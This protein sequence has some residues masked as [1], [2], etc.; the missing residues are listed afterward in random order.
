MTALIVAILRTS[1]KT[2]NKSIFFKRS[3]NFFL[4]GMKVQ[5]DE[6]DER[7]CW[8]IT[9]EA[10]WSSCRRS[11]SSV[12]EFGFQLNS[13]P[14]PH[15]LDHTY[16]QFRWLAQNFLQRNCCVN[17]RSS[18][19][20]LVILTDIKKVKQSRNRPGVA[21]RVPGGLSSQISMTFGTWRWWGRQPHAPAAFT[22]GMFPVL[23]FTR[24]ESTPRP[25]CGR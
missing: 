1:L 5:W 14:F 24:C 3:P 13:F 16:K 12:L 15:I 7:I 20:G 17:R 23:F 6:D 19:I 11:E 25:W 8:A 2:R 10:G 21:Q 22:P 9:P 18:V 4:V